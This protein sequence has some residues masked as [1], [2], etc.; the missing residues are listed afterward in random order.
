MAAET[1]ASEAASE[2]LAR[3]QAVEQQA[4]ELQRLQQRVLLATEERRRRVQ[5][6]AA[7]E[8]LLRSELAAARDNAVSVILPQV[9]GQGCNT[10]CAA[11]CKCGGITCDTLA[12]RT[13]AKHARRVIRH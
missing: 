7:A 13:D 4:S 5:S 6:A 8:E 9:W 2:A 10:P 11:L 3:A 12:C 1:A